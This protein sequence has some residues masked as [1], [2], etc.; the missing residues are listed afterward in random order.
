MEHSF[1][2]DQKET[3][4]SLENNQTFAFGDNSILSNKKTD[5]IYDQEWYEDGYHNYDFLNYTEYNQLLNS[6]TFCIEQLIQKET[7]INTSG[8]TLEQYHKFITND[9][10]HKKI[11]SKTRC[12]FEEH[13]NFNVTD[14]VNKCEDFIRKKLT[15]NFPFSD[16]K[17][18]IIIRINRPFSNDFNPP[19]K[20]IYEFIDSNLNDINMLN[21]WIPI[22]GVNMNS[23]LPLVKGSHLIPENKILRTYEGGIINDNT[24]RVRIIKQWNNNTNLE[25]STVNYKQALLFSPFLIHGLATNTSDITR[26]ALEFRLYNK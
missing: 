9:A 8:F 16:K 20:D 17:Q 22:C 15:F 21:V 3:I 18:W 7:N 10:D 11:V 23:S 1:F 26:V 6:L 19:H 25:R 12:L 2:I 14:L 13:F 24:Y 5:I 4:V